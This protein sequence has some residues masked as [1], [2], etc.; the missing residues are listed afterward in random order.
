MTNGKTIALTRRTFADKA[1]SLLLNTLP[2][3]VIAF[4]PRSNCLNFMATIAV[5]SDLTQEKKFNTSN[6]LVIGK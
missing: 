6:F 1:L 2:R 4:L 5:W 3:V